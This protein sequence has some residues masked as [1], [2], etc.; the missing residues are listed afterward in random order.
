MELNVQRLDTNFD[1]M[2]LVEL[3]RFLRDTIVQ[4]FSVPPEIFG[5]LENSNRATIDAAYYLLAKGA[6]F[7]RI[8]TIAGELQVKL[9][10]EFG[11]GLHLG[12]RNPIP[13]DRDFQLRG[14]SV[15]PSA[16]SRGELRDLLGF[17]PGDDA[18]A[19]LASAEIVSEPTNLPPG[20]GGDPAWTEQR[21]NLNP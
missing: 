1:D 16:F 21:E 9:V 12:F 4:T 20:K 18:D 2:Q 7:P 6:L 15:S 13:E 17:L 11:A 3:R 8:R 19:P 14:V 10:P 5:I